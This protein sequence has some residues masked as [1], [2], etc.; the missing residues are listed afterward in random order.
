MT[1]EQRFD[2]QILLALFKVTVEHTTYLTG[3]YKQKSKQEFVE[4]QRQGFKML[5][6]FEKEN[7]SQYEDI[8]EIAGQLQ[9]IIHEARKLSV[10]ESSL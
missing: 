10:K 7:L 4:W 9:N 5:S 3:A 8:E 2:T 1:P 6:Q